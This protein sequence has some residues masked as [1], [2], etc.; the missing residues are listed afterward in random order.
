MINKLVKGS[1]Q[2]VYIYWAAEKFKGLSV[3]AACPVASCEEVTSLLKSGWNKVS[4]EIIRKIWEHVGYDLSNRKYV[5][6]SLTSYLQDSS[7]LQ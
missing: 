3:D 4:A 1:V 6:F 2:D 5:L 7:A